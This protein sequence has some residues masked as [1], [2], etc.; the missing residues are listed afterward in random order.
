MEEVD[1]DDGEERCRP[2]DDKELR[3]RRAQTVKLFD[4][5]NRWVSVPAGQV[6]CYQS[7]KIYNI[8]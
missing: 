4:G 8:T 5:G 7:D 1:G 2:V 6:H 3:H